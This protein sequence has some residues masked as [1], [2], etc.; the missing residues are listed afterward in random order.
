MLLPLFL[1][2]LCAC[3]VV[4][5]CGSDG[6]TYQNPCLAECAGAK[7]VREGAC[8]APA[9]A[10]RPAPAATPTAPLAPA[11]QPA[12][13]GNG[14][15]CNCPKDKFEPVCGRDGLTYENKW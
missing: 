2:P 4:Q 6:V 9:G 12:A 10:T 3:C 8:V 13:S 15:A 5:V 14:G 7:V 1:T 11:A